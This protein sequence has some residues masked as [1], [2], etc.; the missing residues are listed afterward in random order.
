VNIACT[1]L[2][3]LQLYVN[4]DM[5]VHTG[6]HMQMHVC[7]TS[8]R[9]PGNEILVLH[10]VICSRQV[11]RVLQLR[12]QRGMHADSSAKVSDVLRWVSAM[13]TLTQA[14]LYISVKIQSKG[15]FVPLC[16]TATLHWHAFTSP[17]LTLRIC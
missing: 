2:D 5:H 14:I 9:A 1:S 4:T 7:I 12:V 8:A 13:T 6:S 11:P 3:V 10:P 16:V 15:R 17:N